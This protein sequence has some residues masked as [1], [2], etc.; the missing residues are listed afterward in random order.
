MFIDTTNVSYF[1]NDFN[2][3]NQLKMIYLY[4]LKLYV[5]YG[6]HQEIDHNW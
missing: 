5:R 6:L 2:L 1:F 3:Y 4:E